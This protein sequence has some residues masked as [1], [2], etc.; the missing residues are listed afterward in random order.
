M[1]YKDGTEAKLGDIVRGKLSHVPYEIQGIVVGLSPGATS[2]N[3][4]V[5]TVR[6]T[7]AFNSKLALKK[8]MLLHEYATCADFELVH[9]EQA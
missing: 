8:E 3:V 7:A 6:L 1:H 9:R 5:A 4:I 2:C